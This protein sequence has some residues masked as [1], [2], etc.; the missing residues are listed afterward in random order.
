[1]PR[2]H[3]DK[4]LTVNEALRVYLFRVHCAQMRN[5]NPPETIDGR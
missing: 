2:C 1:L 4:P 3:V 5:L